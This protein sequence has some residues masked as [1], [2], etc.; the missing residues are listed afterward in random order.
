MRYFGRRTLYTVGLS[1]LSS[2]MVIIGGLGWSTSPRAPY[3]IGGLLLL[4]TAIYDCS[5]GP[6]CYTLVSELPSTRL[7]AKT[8]TL[9]RAAY[10]LVSIVITVLVPHMINPLSWNWGAKGG[11]MWAGLAFMSLIWTLVRCP[12]TK[13]RTSG[14]W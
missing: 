9:A 12:E 4:W 11:L 6:V 5:I 7:R 13:G 1:L 14:E 2:L 10:N 3:A 8:A